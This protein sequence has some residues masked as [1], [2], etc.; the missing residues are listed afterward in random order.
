MIQVTT[1]LWMI[2]EPTNHITFNTSI[3][4][5]LKAIEYAEEAEGSD[6]IALVS[7]NGVLLQPPYTPFHWGEIVD[8]MTAAQVLNWFEDGLDLDWGPP[9]EWGRR[10]P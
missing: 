4:N 7:I 3:D 10:M 1:H 9:T 8:E 5:L 6:I 2:V